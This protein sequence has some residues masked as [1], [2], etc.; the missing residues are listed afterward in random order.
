ML[1]GGEH[2]VIKPTSLFLLKDKEEEE[3]VFIVL[4]EFSKINYST[5]LKIAN[6]LIEKI[7]QETYQF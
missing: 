6:D 1:R 4:N 2:N 3:F 5:V 7:T